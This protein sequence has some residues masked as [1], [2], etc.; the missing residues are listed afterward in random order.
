MALLAAVPRGSFQ[1]VRV[2]SLDELVGLSAQELAAALRDC[3]VP[4]AGAEELFA[5]VLGRVAAR[6]NI[7]DGLTALSNMLETLG[8][9]GAVLDAEAVGV[10]GELLCVYPFEVARLYARISDASPGLSPA[11]LAEMA[12]QLLR[13]YASADLRRLS[14]T[15]QISAQSARRILGYANRFLRR[16]L[17]RA[18]C[19]D[20][21][22]LAAALEKR[23]GSQLAKTLHRCVEADP[24]LREAVLG[25]ERSLD[26][27]I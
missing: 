9:P 6:E 3:S 18:G 16:A 14:S 1:S 10:L 13:F 12:A 4:F 27:W 2:P 11:L 5:L 23:S 15:F 22:A 19:A 24:E 25:P 8:D 21:E 26:L 20:P 17:P 7:R